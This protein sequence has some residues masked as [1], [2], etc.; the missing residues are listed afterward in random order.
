MDVRH[1]AAN[2]AAANRLDRLRNILAVAEQDGLEPDG[3]VGQNQPSALT[4]SST[5]F[6]ASARSIMVLSR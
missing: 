6:F 5:I 3:S 1:H 2:A 4:I